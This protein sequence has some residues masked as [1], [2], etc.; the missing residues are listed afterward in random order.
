MN[1]TWS[2]SSCKEFGIPLMDAL[3]LTHGKWTIPI[4]M[5]LSYKGVMRFNEMKY[6][7]SGI[8]SRI[9]SRELKR[10]VINKL[11]NRTELNTVPMTV[12][13]ELTEHGKSLLPIGMAL[14]EWGKTH[15]KEMFN[16]TTPN[17]GYK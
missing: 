4:I 13:Y 14:V 12:R 5:A 10:L 17:N 9:L 1:E 11:I 16:K 3:E 7:V 2:L 8:S 6:S 15:R